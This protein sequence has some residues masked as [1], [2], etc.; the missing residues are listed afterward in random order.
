[1]FHVRSERMI[2]PGRHWLSASARFT[3]R[4]LALLNRIHPRERCHSYSP[5]P[6]P[7]SEC[8]DYIIAGGLET[9]ATAAQRCLDRADVHRACGESR[10]TDLEN[11]DGTPLLFGKRYDEVS[12]F[13]PDALLREARR[14]KN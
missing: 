9:L 6:L 12:V 5:C 14:Q 10:G 7:Q 1:M 3:S 13:R 4:A 2:P 11:F 8:S